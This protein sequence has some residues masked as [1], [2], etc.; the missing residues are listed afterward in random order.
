MLTISVVYYV[1]P[2]GTIYRQVNISAIANFQNSF[3]KF[4]SLANWYNSCRT[5]HVIIQDTNTTAMRYHGGCICFLA[6]D[7]F[8]KTI[9]SGDNT[10]MCKCLH[11]IIQH[12]GMLNVFKRLNVGDTVLS[13]CQI[14]THVAKDTCDLYQ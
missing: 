13:S 11:Y 9:T 7:N 12:R 3:T 2:G 14:L 8:Q 6:C 1:T 10:G 4:T 5:P